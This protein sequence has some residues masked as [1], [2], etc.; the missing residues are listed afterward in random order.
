VLVLDFSSQLV[1]AVGV[2]VLFAV[3]GVVFLIRH[4]GHR[5]EQ[6]TARLGEYTQLG[7]HLPASLH[8]VIDPDLC[9][10]SQA[11]IRACPEGDII[12]LV[13]GAAKLIHG[14]K[15]IG[16]G[17]CAD[18]CP[19]DAIRLVF[20]TEERG[21]DL[22]SLGENF[23]SSRK[24]VY[25][26]GELGG[27]GLIKNAVTQGVQVGTYLGK[28]LNQRQGQ[29]PAVVIVGAGPAGLGTA[30]A[31][32]QAG[33]SYKL[34]EQDTVGGTVAH[35]PRQ[36]LVMTERVQVPGFGRFGKAQMRKEELVGSFEALVEATGLKIEN[37]VKV[38]GIS[39]EAG[40]FKIATSKGPIQAQAVVLAIGR[41]GSPRRLEAEGEDL[42]KVT[43]RLV[44]PRQ[45]EAKRMLVVGGGDS[46]LESAIMLAEEAKGPVAISYRRDAFARCRQANKDKID[47]LIDEGK[48]TAYLG[49][50][51]Q[52][53]EADTVT[54]AVGDR[55]LVLPNDYVIANLGGELPTKFLEA[56]GVQV[57]THRGEHLEHVPGRS[58]ENDDRVHR[59]LELG[60]FILGS[61]ITAALMVV[62]WDYY[63]TPLALRDTLP[64]HEALKPAG[65]WGHGIGVVATAVMLLNFLYALR[66]RFSILRNA[67]SIRSWLTFH[68]FVGFLSPIVIAFHA[69]FQSNNLLATVTLFALLT[70][71]ATGI[72]G[73]F[74]W[75]LVP[76]TQGHAL[77]QNELRALWEGQ[78]ERLRGVM[79]D[80]RDSATLNALL[81]FAA[82][83]P[84]KAGSLFGA[85]A[86]IPGERIR[87]TRRLK[88]ARTLFP[89]EAHFRSFAASIRSLSRMRFQLG[90]YRSLRRLLSAWRAFHVVLAIL[91][92]L[93]IAAHVAYALFLGYGWIFM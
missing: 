78:L 81:D 15:C 12:G 73:R 13:D 82:R 23:E 86:S 93:V 11:C 40:N 91:M 90:F 29:D 3:L 44:D 9:I 37:K 85:L 52:R 10:G 83:Q 49:S 24:G 89:D 1:L 43:Y 2:V 34:L 36:K 56:C 57:K 22:P 32:K 35:Y 30:A 48:I 65:W 50:T 74:I 70:V 62:G 21:V 53:I 47:A 67:G 58:V 18:E 42:E 75:G 27:M 60:L 41:R 87:I 5:D 84:E 72:L 69:A 33:V 38:E 71:V 4:R 55:T 28:T 39:G 66:K 92:V 19:V 59:R 31:L 64:V 6:S 17:R 54:L 76:S 51:V 26:A 80:V 61:L 79:G 8:P 7:L 88:R 77:E 16:H 63:L 14:A 25:I 45:Y 68:L 46:A 20:G